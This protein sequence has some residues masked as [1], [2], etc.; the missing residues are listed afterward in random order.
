VVPQAEPTA[1]P[2]PSYPVDIRR[3]YVVKEG[4]TYR[5]LA[6]RFDVK[7]RDIRALNGG[8]E[9]VVG[10]RIRIPAEPWVTDAPDD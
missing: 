9:L 6:R 2:R 1:T 8:G 10:K 5:T 7:P 4:D 3:T